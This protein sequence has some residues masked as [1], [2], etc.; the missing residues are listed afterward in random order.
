MCILCN[1]LC[2]SL[3]AIAIQLT[4]SKSEHNHVFLR[5]ILAT[6][7]SRHTEILNKFKAILPVFEFSNKDHRDVV[8]TCLKILMSEALWKI[9]LINKLAIICINL[10][11]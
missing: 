1:I 4:H 3:T 7:M 2:K 9:D 6:D 11:K 5:C 8:K 10:L